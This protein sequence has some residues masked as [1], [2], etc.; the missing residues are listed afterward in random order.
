MSSPKQIAANRRNAQK[1]TGPRTPQGRA[2]VRFNALKHGLTAQE[3]V[4]P[5]E[6]KQ[7][8]AQLLE[9]LLADRRPVG[10]VETMLVHRMAVASWQLHRAYVVETASFELRL[11]RYP[12]LAARENLNDSCMLA[13]VMRERWDSLN[14]FGNLSRYEAKIERTFYRALHEL[15]QLQDERKSNFAKQCQ[16]DDRTPGDGSSPIGPELVDGPPSPVEPEPRQPPAAS[17]TPVQLPERCLQLSLSLSGC[18]SRGSLPPPLPAFENLGVSP[19][20]GVNLLAINQQYPLQLPGGFSGSLHAPLP[21]HPPQQRPRRARKPLHLPPLPRPTHRHHRRPQLLMD[22]R[23]L[24]RNQLADQHVRP[25]LQL[26]QRPKNGATLG[27]PPPR[28]PHR[29]PNHHPR[30]ARQR[31]IRLQQQPNLADHFPAPGT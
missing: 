23:D 31:S 15:R 4:L 1:N 5:T 26:P 16:S 6:D 2:A 22:K 29:L 30:H 24:P 8:F 17:T 14:P 25:R 12:N 21:R 27:M 11:I 9:S 10:P 28:S 3:A 18:D 20:L 13:H 7:A 19:A